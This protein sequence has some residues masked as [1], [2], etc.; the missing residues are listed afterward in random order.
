VVPTG[1]SKEDLIAAALADERIAELLD[2]KEMR[3][4]IA[5]PDRLVNIVAT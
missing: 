1:T 4:T 3:K 5:V 2:G